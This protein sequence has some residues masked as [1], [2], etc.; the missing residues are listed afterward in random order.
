MINFNYDVTPQQ[1]DSSMGFI[2]WLQLLFI[3][4]KMTHYIDW[5]WW[6]VMMPFIALYT[7]KV[8]QWVA[9]KED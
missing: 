2:D 4:L 7:I 6:Y 8:I 9:T 3:A 5:S 1:P